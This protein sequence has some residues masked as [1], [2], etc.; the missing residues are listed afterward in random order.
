ML[1]AVLAVVPALRHLRYR[2]RL[3][4]EVRLRNFQVPAPRSQRI[5]ARGTPTPRHHD[6]GTPLAASPAVAAAASPPVPERAVLYVDATGR[7]T[8]AD[9]AAR[10]LLQWNSGELS[11]ADVVA[12]G[13]PE[14]ADLLATL[15]RDGTIETHATR[16]RTPHD[17][18][19]D[20]TAVAV[21][22]RDDNLWGAAFF[23]R[24]THTPATEA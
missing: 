16:L 10:A 20:L 21:R 6:P 1:A 18:P 7:C 24:G 12:G 22:D 23:I 4:L 15:A 19:V 14:A 2:R 8:L 17:L 11:L 5:T 13:V 9:D 3:L